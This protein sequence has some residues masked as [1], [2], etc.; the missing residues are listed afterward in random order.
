MNQSYDSVSRRQFLADTCKVS[1]GIIAAGTLAS[2]AGSGQTLKTNAALK[3]IGSNNRIN[4]AVIGARNRGWAV[5]GGF[6]GNDVHLKAICD[7]DGNILDKRASEVQQKYNYKP[8]TYKDMRKMFEDSQIDAVIV[9]IPNHWHALATVWACQADK[10]V[11]V[12]KPACHNVFEGR[13]MVQAARKYNRLVQVGFQNRSITNVRKA[14]E[15][16][17]SGGIGDIYMARGLCYKPRDPIGICK[18]GIGTGPEYDYWEFNK[19]GQKYTAEYMAKVDYDM[20]T[21]PAPV[22]PFNYNR[23]HYNWH[24]NYLYGGGDISNQ[25]PH[26]FDVARWGLGKNEHPVQIS[27]SGNLSHIKS[28]QDTA[29]TQTASFKYADGTMLVFEVRGY[30]TNP[31]MNITVGN[32]FYGTKGWMWLDGSRWATFMGRNNEPGPTSDSKNEELSADP[33]NVAGAGS[34][35]HANNFIAALRS[36]KVSDL[37]CDIEEGFMSSALPAMANISYRLG[38]TLNF[39]GKKEKFIGDYKA[40]QM[41]TRDYRKPYIVPNNV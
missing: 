9:G 22:R 21:G 30:Y 14:M 33:M 4:V 24:W 7:I 39:D 13:K 20:W 17:K 36:G 31:E 34:G 27:S 32:L 3:P 8:D 1:A 35:G 41:L 10:H 23:F 26:Q 5:A 19:K 2:C 12:E 25:G 18:D 15:F 11:Y 16:L 29:H 28:D 40:N 37:T 6:M 38:R